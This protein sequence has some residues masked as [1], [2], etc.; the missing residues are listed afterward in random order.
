MRRYMKPVRKELKRIRPLF[1]LYLWSID[2]YNLFRVT[3]FKYRNLRLFYAVRPF[4]MVPYEGLFNVHEL[5][6]LIEDKK[7]PGAFVE[8]G[9]WKGGC[10]ALMAAVA[11][12]KGGGRLTWLFD[13]FEGLPEPTGMDGVEARKLAKNRISGELRPIGEAVG[14]LESVEEVFSKLK[15]DPQTIKIVK[16]WFQDSLP[17][18][19]DKIGPI[20]LLRLDGDWYESTKTCLEN[21]YDHV[22]P[23]GYIIIDDYGHWEGCQK[24]VD[25]FLGNRELSVP[26]IKAGYSVVYFQKSK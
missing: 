1:R 9:V 17:N 23:G 3:G 12:K 7:I 2:L 4:T 11:K 10:S 26:F 14:T 6:N 21:L 16:G 25:A 18:Y 8:C 19:K 22:V 20:S 15:I 13:S 5:A 24:A